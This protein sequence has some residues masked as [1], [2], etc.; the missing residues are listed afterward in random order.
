MLTHSGALLQH[1][2]RG[3]EKAPVDDDA[4]LGEAAQTPIQHRE[5]CS[6]AARDAHRIGRNDRDHGLGAA[7]SNAAPSRMSAAASIGRAALRFI[8]GSSLQ[9][10]DSR[11]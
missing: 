2:P 6:L 5:P 1:L 9:I 3:V 7:D 4:A 8:V 10:F 11:R